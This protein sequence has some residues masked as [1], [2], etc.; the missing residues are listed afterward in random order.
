MNH[1]QLKISLDGGKTFQDVDPK[2][3]V[4]VKYENT[5]L[6]TILDGSP[7]EYGDVT[8]TFTN[9]SVKQQIHYRQEENQVVRVAY[10]VWEYMK[11][12]RFT[13]ASK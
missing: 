7:T 3:G 10:T 5:A 13:W 4:I 8:T 2:Q 11:N 6:N 9:S 12:I 1:N